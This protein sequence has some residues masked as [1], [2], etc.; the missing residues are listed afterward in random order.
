M[1]DSC[2]A[3]FANVS[4]GVGPQS[5]RKPTAWLTSDHSVSEKPYRGMPDLGVLAR[6]NTSIGEGGG[7]DS[8]SGSGSGCGR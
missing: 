2:G 1:S 4:S 3:S 5:L 7:N 8:G 6:C